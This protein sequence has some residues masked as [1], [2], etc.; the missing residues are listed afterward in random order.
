MASNHVHP[1]DPS[2][3]NVS[4][5]GA[6]GQDHLPFTDP[7]SQGSAFPTSF[8]SDQQASHL[9]ATPPSHSPFNQAPAFSPPAWQSTSTPSA[10]IPSSLP[11]QYLTANHGYY[12]LPTSSSGSAFV[13]GHG[14][15][16]TNVDPSL[17][18]QG[19]VRS[20][21][22]SPGLSSTA[23]RSASAIAPA[24]L[25][26]GSPATPSAVST[27]GTSTQGV[28]SQSVAIQQRPLP[29]SQSVANGNAAAHVRT[30]PKGTQSGNFIIVTL[31]DLAK[32][33]PSK[34]LANFA[35]VGDIPVDLNL[36]KVNIPQYVPR[37]SQNEL[38]ALAA[39]DP[40]LKAKIMKR[41][42]KTKLSTP[43]P[44]R[45][46]QSTS[47]KGS[48]VSLSSETESSDYDSDS[49]YDSDASPPPEKSPLPPSRPQKAVEAVR[50][51][52]IKAV[53]L[54]RNKFAENEKIL[55]GLADLWEVVRT[56]KDRWKT[57]RDAVKKA[58]ELKQDSELPLLRERVEKQLELMEAVLNAAV[59][60]GHPDLLS[61]CGQNTAL[62][63]VCY[64]F[65]L[66][67]VREGNYTGSFIKAVFKFLSLCTNL[68]GSISEKTGLSKL[69]TRSIK[70]G[71]EEIKLLTAKINENIAAS[72]KKAK[73][74]RASDSKTAKAADSPKAPKQETEVV[75][76]VKRARSN[77]GS[78]TPQAK[79]VASGTTA[80]GGKD[81]AAA[82]LGSVKKVA[83]ASS[84]TPAVT[85]KPK[86]VKP[87]A[88]TNFFAGLQSASKKPGTSNAAQAAKKVTAG[89]TVDK[90][91]AAAAMPTPARPAF[92][93]AET[94]ATLS[95]EKKEDDEKPNKK[96]SEET[97]PP[98]TEE[99]K[100]KR[101]RKEERRKLRVRWK[102]DFELVE[103]RT[104]SPDPSEISGKA[105]NVRDVGNGREKEGFTL[106]KHMDMMEVDED[107][108]GQPMEQTYFDYRE[109][110]AVDFSTVPEDER[111]RNFERFGGYQKVDSPERAV[112]DNHEA[113][114][115]MVHYL[116]KSDIPP[117][118]R[119]P[120]DPYTG[121]QIETKNFGYPD[122]SCPWLLARLNQ[123]STTAPATVPQ[124][125][126]T[127]LL[128]SFGQ[129]PQQAP[130]P[131]PQP[132]SAP[133]LPDLSTLQ[134]IIA[135][136]NA[137]SQQA[138]A[139]QQQSFSWPSAPSQPASSA[140]EPEQPSSL[141]SILA[142]LGAGVQASQPTTTTAP[143]IQP[144]QPPPPPPAPAP[145]TAAVPS[146]DVSALLASLMQNAQS[147]SSSTASPFQG[148]NLTT[149]AGGGGQDQTQGGNYYGSA[150]ASSTDQY[151]SSAANG[152]D[153][154]AN[155]NGGKRKWQGNANK[156]FTHACR[157]WKEGKCKKGAECTFRH[158]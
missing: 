151:V 27:P 115:L 76:G 142:A 28:V 95:K 8:L 155:G 17:Y 101:L 80:P 124:I 132:V 72:D 156:K 12:P 20:F 86:T 70:R 38:K 34:K 147:G 51:D 63:L 131:T 21:G 82:K 68:N 152:N 22:S 158:D 79:R 144:S 109:P 35:N 64:Q 140:T 145:P 62:M 123:H 77:E 71:N 137:A 139:A 59:E 7:Y 154:G 52:T 106:K 126:I 133:A 99:E 146:S 32:V 53:W 10:S 94:M 45:P 31:E 112:Q 58:L 49:S 43:K 46:L 135:N 36:T 42:R 110:T 113:N 105:R 9:N 89:A 129:Q 2:L 73:A 149:A 111:C 117:N 56:I 57:D 66:E 19:D 40:A 88:T 100:A 41:V 116:A 83:P 50:Y 143:P 141:E 26:R 121:P 69:F 3:Q 14:S 85:A 125:D 15:P 18:R 16:F 136:V 107:D 4:I 30:A 122:S 119:E 33:T 134:S 92:S 55:K 97:R 104:F 102:P 84:S 29:P 39:S 148:L 65:I 78:V 60:F 1:P 54:P 118:P 114:T 128:Q 6:E 74:A 96:K 23:S 81:S 98:E 13:A 127:A 48:P 90:K 130:Q 108:D 150:P 75:A 5:F 37:K 11:N 24:P 87:A 103:T 157:F 67:P 91:G 44:S 47:G 93:F 153:Q 120:A 25:Q 138:S 61:A